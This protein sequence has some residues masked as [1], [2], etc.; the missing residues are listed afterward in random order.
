MERYN[1]RGLAVASEIALPDLAPIASVGAPQLTIRRGVVPDELPDRNADGPLWQAGGVRF[2]LRI[3]KFANFLIEDGSDIVVEPDGADAAAIGN[4]LLGTVLGLVFHQRRQILL[5]ASAVRV[6]DR[7][8]L[9]CGASGEGK[10]TIAAAL[11]QRGY[12]LLADDACAVSTDAAGSPTVSPDPNHLR[13]SLQAIERLDLGARRGA[14]IAQA[15]ERHYVDPGP[16]DME[17]R[18]L[19]A[20]YR[21]LSAT[22]D[23]PTSI[24]AQRPCAA[25]LT[26]RGFAHRPL[27]VEQLGQEAHYFEAVTAIAAAAGVFSLTRA[28]DFARMEEVIDALEEHWRGLGFTRT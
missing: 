13:L 15:A 23:T 4:V 25:A 16:P 21:L 24:E 20:V 5:H 2:L 28:K 26:L 14:R 18:P 10:S 6:G 8:V 7:A 12:R 9:F 1:V 3:P 17:A 19:G 22:A 11:T 27:M